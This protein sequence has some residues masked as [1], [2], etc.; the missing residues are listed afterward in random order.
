MLW[1]QRH[2]VPSVLAAILVV[3]GLM[4]FLAVVGSIVGSSIGAF[5][6]ALPGYQAQLSA[7][8]QSSLQFI[9]KFV[10]F[11]ISVATIA[12]F[13]DPGRAMGMAATL[14]GA[15]RGVLTNT[16]LILFTM[17][18]ILLEVSS[19]QT[20]VMAAFGRGA[21]SFERA[22]A[23]FAKPRSVSWNQD[24]R[25]Y[26]HRS[27]CRNH[28]MDDRLGFSVA[29][30]H[31]RISAQLHPNDRFDNCGGTR[32]LACP[33]TTRASGSGDDSSWFSW[34]QHGVRQYH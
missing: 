32:C 17:V 11:D 22:G 6:V 12:E 23:F 30:G 24:C 18:F 20:K 1:L 21:D 26:G 5:T 19:V 31:A 3:F 34:N 8:L 29:L 15:L 2:R 14:L 16:F 7:L 10:E 33:G 4:L 27:Y 28:D 13:I 25:K 9:Q